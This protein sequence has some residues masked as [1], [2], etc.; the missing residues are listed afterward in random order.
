MNADLKVGTDSPERVAHACRLML[1]RDRPQATVGW[2]ESLFVRVNAVAPGIVDGAISKQLSVIQR[3]AAEN[4]LQG[5][6]K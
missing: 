5:N 1:E 2:P 4:I 6:S 3:Y